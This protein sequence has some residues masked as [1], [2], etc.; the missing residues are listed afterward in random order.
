MEAA[1]TSPL[2][3]LPLDPSGGNVRAANASPAPRR[4]GT[5]S[6]FWL[7]WQRQADD[8]GELGTA[9]RAFTDNHSPLN[10]ASCLYDRRDLRHHA[11]RKTIRTLIFDEA[12]SLPPEVPIVLT[13]ALADDDH[14]RAM[15]EDVRGLAARRGTQLVAVVLGCSEEENIRRIVSLERAALKKLTDIEVIK[16]LRAGYRLLRSEGCPCIDL[17]VSALSANDAAAAIEASLRNH[18]SRPPEVR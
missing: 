12:V 17:D 13:D 5:G 10:P 8:R 2:W 14:D 16:S 4:D 7:A 3:T 1:A 9:R 11:L 15:F 6:A 18:M